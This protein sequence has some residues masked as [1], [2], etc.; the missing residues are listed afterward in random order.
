M[1]RKQATAKADRLFSLRVRARGECQLAPLFPTITCNGGLQCCHVVSRRYKAVRWDERNA[2]AGCA[3]HHLY[4]T[5][6]PLE[7]QE[8]MER[9]VPY[10]SIRHAA[11]NQPPM[12]PSVVIE[13]LEAV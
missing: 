3:A 12:D 9:T 1:N 4:G 11:L 10:A 13:R 8:A 6:H 2:L 5:H 7:W